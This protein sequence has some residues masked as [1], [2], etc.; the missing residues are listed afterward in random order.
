MKLKP[1]LFLP[2][3]L[4]SFSCTSEDSNNNDDDDS[5][6]GVLISQINYSAA[7]EDFSYTETFNYIEN[8]L[9]SIVESDSDSND[10]YNTTFEYDNDKLVRVDFLDLNEL[11]EYVTLEY[12]AEGILTSFTTFLFDVDGENVATKHTLNYD[13]NNS[14]ISLDLYRGDFSSQTEFFGTLEY[15]ISNGNIIETSC[16][17]SDDT[18]SYQYDTKNAAYK[19]IFDIET[20]ILIMDNTESGLEIYGAT[21]NVTQRTDVQSDFPYTETTGYTYN[22]N[23]YPSTAMYYYDNVLDSNIEFIYE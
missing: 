8:R 1:F 5:Q 16:D 6:D 19:N 17:I 10:E 11:V 3:L 4:L 7:D 23:D 12:N 21:N 18:E 9:I 13:E 14:N 2:L 20:I 15:V 22:S